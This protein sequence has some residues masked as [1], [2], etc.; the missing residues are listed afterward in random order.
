[1]VQG[2]NY[3]SSGSEN[4]Q[5]DYHSFYDFLKYFVFY[6]DFCVYLFLCPIKGFHICVIGHLT[7]LWMIN[8]FSWQS[9][10]KRFFLVPK[11]R[12]FSHIFKIVTGGFSSFCHNMFRH[13]HHFQCLLYHFTHPLH[14]TNQTYCH[15]NKE[16]GWRWHILLFPTFLL[17]LEFFLISLHFI[18]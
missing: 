11:R 12:D 15:E 2:L 6:F 8:C 9:L 14:L 7:L 4:G 10:Q 17:Q 1:M 13:F 18:K 16:V 3:I 5:P